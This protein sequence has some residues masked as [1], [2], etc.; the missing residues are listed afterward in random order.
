MTRLTK[1]L[2]TLPMLAAMV[3]VLG[4]AGP[5]ATPLRDLRLRLKEKSQRTICCLQ[6]TFL[7]TRLVKMGRKNMC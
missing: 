5:P 7:F 3:F 6:N 2:I 1:G 4:G